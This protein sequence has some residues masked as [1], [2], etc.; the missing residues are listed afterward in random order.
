MITDERKE[1]ELNNLEN[2]LSDLKYKDK[3]DSRRQKIFFT[4]GIIILIIFLSTFFFL[5]SFF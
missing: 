3:R 5:M 1:R 2:I 4:L